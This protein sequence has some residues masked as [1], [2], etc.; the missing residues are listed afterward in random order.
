MTEQKFTSTELILLAHDEWLR[1]E[2]RKNIHEES[3]WVSGFLN[4]F[5]T[6]KKWAREYVGKLLQ[7]GDHP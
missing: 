4:G 5:C 1:R 7:A 6:D 2:K 3:A